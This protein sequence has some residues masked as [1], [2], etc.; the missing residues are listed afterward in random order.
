MYKKKNPVPSFASQS[1]YE[2]LFKNSRAN[3][4][5][6]GV[7]WSGVGGTPAVHACASCVTA[8]RSAPAA[9]HL[10]THCAC[11]FAAASV[12]QGPSPLRSA[13][14]RS[15]RLIRSTFRRLNAWLIRSSS[16]HVRCVS[17]FVQSHSLYFDVRP[18][19]FVVF[20]RF[21]GGLT[22]V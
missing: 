7:E 12:V 1:S 16:N 13:P 15:A 10:A 11:P 5:K 8:S 18:I 6:S 9:A 3:K 21:S 14:L 2:H 17:T 4:R 20:A 22:E 19:T